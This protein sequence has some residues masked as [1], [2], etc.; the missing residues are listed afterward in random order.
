MRRCPICARSYES[1]Q[2][3]CSIHGLPLVE[4][5]AVGHREKGELTGL[6]LDSRYRLAGVAGKGG[7]GI[8]YEAE[9]IRI[10]RRC[11]VKVLHPEVQA[12]PKMRMR[13][14]REVQATS[15]VRHPNVVD[16]LDFG[17][18]ERAGS[19]LVMEFLEGRS[20]GEL[21]R[22]EG[23]LR[24]PHILRIATQL[25]SALSATHAHGLIHRDLKPSNVR[26]LP[27]GT[28]KVLDFGL[29]KPYER[30]TARDFVTI[31]TGG[32][33]FGTPWY[34]S[35]E[36]AT[37][38]PLDP[39]SDIYSFGVILYEA[40][41]GQ[42]PF[43]GDNPLELIDAHR[44]K[45]VPLPSRLDPPVTIHPAMEMLV[46]KALCKEPERRFQTINELL[47]GLLGVAQQAGVPLS[48]LELRAPS[49]SVSRMAHVEEELAHVSS[50]PEWTLPVPLQTVVSVERMREAVLSQLDEIAGRVVGALRAVIPRYRT[51]DPQLLAESS[52]VTLLTA[53]KV[54]EE[55]PL[56]E[57]PEEMQRLADQ[58]SVQQFTP[59]EI[60]GA[61]W[62]ELSTIR[63]VFMELGGNDF[64]AMKSIEE[65]VDQ[66]IL[67]FILKLV[68]YYFSRYHL[69]LVQLNETLSRQNEELIQL[70]S[71]L[72]DQLNQASRQLIEAE[73][74]KARVVETISS[75]VVLIERDSRRVKIFNRMMEKL[76]GVA[77][78]QAIGRPIE[79]VLSFVDGVPFD[80]FTEQIRLHGQVGL[81]KLWVR[82][83]NGAQRA[84]YL[85]G[86]TFQDSLGAV[87]GTLF[88]IDDVTE[89]EHIVES[90]SRY[91]SREVV[92]QVLRRGR[93]LQPTGDTRRA[94]LLAANIRDFRRLSK[95]LAL[96][97]VV[98][99]LTDYVR[100]VSD[101]VFRHGGSIHTVVGDGM[102]VY[103]DNLR[104]TC[105]P[106]VKAAVELLARLE[107]V[108]QRREERKLPRIDVGVGIH[109]GEVLVANVGGKRRMV[110]TVVGDAALVAQALQEVASGGEILVTS[111][112]AKSV[113]GF[114]LEN[115][116]VVSV[117]GQA[118]PIEAFRVA[119]DLEPI[120]EPSPE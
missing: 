85:S 18:D 73:Q 80:E 72:T 107:G 50:E 68:D 92:D 120:V 115:G 22:T 118:Q 117:D 102:L 56:A 39:R 5:L 65:F 44:S 59:S 95:P 119:F 24:L 83:P 32:I 26:I 116:P 25:A 30:D 23:P 53:L 86:Q 101:A 41:V 108:N 35:P 21:L 6:V 1:E 112:V 67:S 78:S 96:D 48:E 66:R 3:F 76:S 27:D 52:K 15:R 2:R 97:A 11:A 74:L 77:A 13:L 81:R 38:Q 88:I 93:S 61:M 89:R 4:E 64:A 99:L 79:E 110:H 31:T 91:L 105:T 17:D 103:F 114:K 8:V 60:I 42:P 12:D 54:F 36:Q 9:N 113:E 69:R 20:L 51:I 82:L 106:A 16:I 49:V 58:R 84:V 40:V 70:R 34:M 98:E 57:L 55:E 43:T 87:L 94:V 46:L 62:M 45:P 63:P 19:Y 90:F 7:M 33:A 104:E 71:A 111:E 109:V 14:F 28:V 47:E 100:A 75:G 37:F 10:G 29:V